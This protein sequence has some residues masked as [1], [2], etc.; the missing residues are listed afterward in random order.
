MS[1]LTLKACRLALRRA[2]HTKQQLLKQRHKSSTAP[3][4]NSSSPIVEGRTVPTP[5]TVPPLPLWQRLGPLSTVFTA[6]G[7]SQR[8]R[9]YTTQLC[10]SLII[11]LCGDLAAQ[12]IGDEVYNPWR[13][14]RN[15]IIGGI[16]SI[17]S[18]KWHVI[19]RPV[20]HRP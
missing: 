15:M 18:Y 7:R 20:L 11:Y 19:L 14:V 5:N 2:G 3:P 1:V 16:C 12:N 4:S 6:F 13:T 8:L 9:P 10:S 17:P